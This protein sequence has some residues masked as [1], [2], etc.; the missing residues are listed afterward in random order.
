MSE[1]GEMKRGYIEMSNLT[2]DFGI[3]TSGYKTVSCA[4]REGTGTWSGWGR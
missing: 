2:D 3:D 1:C 4:L